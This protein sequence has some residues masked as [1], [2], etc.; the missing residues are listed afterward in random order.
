MIAWVSGQFHG[1]QG[2]PSRWARVRI[3]RTNNGT[4]QRTC[5]RALQQPVTHFEVPGYS[6]ETRKDSAEAVGCVARGRNWPLH[7]Y[8]VLALAMPLTPGPPHGECAEADV[9]ATNTLLTCGDTCVVTNPH[10]ALSAL[11]V[12][13]L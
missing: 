3:A 5:G 4:L 1:S 6:L 2:C 12:S 9:E 7:S 10:T 11:R 13:V 8:E